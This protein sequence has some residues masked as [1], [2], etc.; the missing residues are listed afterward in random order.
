MFPEKRF[1][2]QLFRHGAR[3]IEFSYPNDP[4]ANEQMYWPEGYGQLTD[5]SSNLNRLKIGYELNVGVFLNV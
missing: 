4:W 2:Q 5:V 1:F 3:N